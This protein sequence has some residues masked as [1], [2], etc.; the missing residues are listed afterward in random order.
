MKTFGVKVSNYDRHEFI[1]IRIPVEKRE[2][3]VG[4]D[5]DGDEYV[6]VDILQNV[7]TCS[8]ERR[9]RKALGSMWVNFQL[10]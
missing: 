5:I 9:I 3:I 2:R 8:Q 4:V 7:I 10:A 6:R 1:T